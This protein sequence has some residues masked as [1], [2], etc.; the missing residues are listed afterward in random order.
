MGKQ[1]QSLKFG[2][3]VPEVFTVGGVQTYMC[4]LLDVM[5]GI[6]DEGHS[7][8]CLSVNDIS[9]RVSQKSCVKSFGAGRSKLKYL[10]LAW[11][12][13]RNTNYLLV[14]HIGQA[15]VAWFLKRLGLIEK[16]GV[17]LHGIE[18][19]KRLPILIRMAL[20]NANDIIATTYYTAKICIKKNDL[21]NKKLTIIPL[22]VKNV[23]VQPSSFKLKGAFKILCVGRQEKTEEGK[24]YHMLI[25]AMRQLRK[26]PSVHLNMVGDGDN[27]QHL[28]N[29]CQTKG[30]KNHVTFWGRLSDADL[31]SAYKDCDV[32]VMPSKKEGFGIVFLEAMRWGK[33]CIGGNY[34]GTPEVIKE[35][36][37]GFLVDFD[38]VP[39]L[40][41]RLQ[42]FITNPQ[43]C[44][45]YGRIGLTLIKTKYRFN[46]FNDEFRHLLYKTRL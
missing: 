27:Q 22:C 44:T 3:L 41:Q 36:E 43:L 5:E 9:E 46:L 32:F 28:V 18:A 7:A 20:K 33:P 4:R 15:P 6:V 11:K 31:Q 35:G 17:I 8:I 12:H 1:K 42:Q 34:G 39:M 24:G 21:E 45:R 14:G 38:D 13:I 16:Y 40:V 26:Y 19:W 29:F 2:L 23:V 10:M 30:L 25:E 37:S